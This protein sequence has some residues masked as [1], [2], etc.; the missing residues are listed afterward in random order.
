MSTH[1]TL[2]A[3]K[4]DEQGKGAARR[5]RAEGRVPAV[6]YGKDEETMMLSV[7]AKEAEQVFQA[8]S[9]ENTLVDV[10]I[11]G[12]RG[13]VATL[14]REVQVHP[15]RPELI[16]IDFYRIQKDVAVE[17]E[18]PIHLV[19]TPEGV[20]SQGGVLEQIVHELAVKC[21]PDS[22]P[23]SFEIDVTGLTI[24]D[25]I[26]V[27]DIDTAEGVEMLVDEDQTVCT[28]VTPRVVEVEGEEEE[29]AEALAG[30]A[31]GEEE[32]GEGPAEAPGVAEA[33][34]EG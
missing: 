28:V 7:S 11:K 10:K 8:I 18:V 26:H 30:V 32:A 13:A 1:A 29:E 2:N 4:R 3:E 6:I 9:V 23:E 27:S 16:H 22:I 21:L 15:Y 34:E 12:Q 20:K 25:A 31:E 19:G 17:V 33:E 24:G 5:M 14:V